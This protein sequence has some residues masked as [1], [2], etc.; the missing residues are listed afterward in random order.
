[1]KTPVAPEA[2]PEA[3]PEVTPATTDAPAAAPEATAT[4][5]APARTLIVTP[6]AEGYRRAGRAWTREPTR[7]AYDALDEAQ[8]KALQ[9]DP[10]IDLAIV[11]E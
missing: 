2:T 1:M 10:L 4:P 6:H 3:T 5:A 8:L 9:D 7:I 11:E